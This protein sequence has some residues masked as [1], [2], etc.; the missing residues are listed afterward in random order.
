MPR[1]VPSQVVAF[2]DQ[3]LLDAGS[4]DPKKQPTL[5]ASY[6]GALGALIDLVDS[7]PDELL[8]L[9]PADYGDP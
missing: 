6:A 5:S 4:E 8:V 2:I 7:L 3:H 1:V 9:S